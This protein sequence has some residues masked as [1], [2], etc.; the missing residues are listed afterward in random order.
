MKIFS[1][2]ITLAALS[3]LTLT[4]ASYAQDNADN[5]RG[6][7][8]AEG[9][10]ER[11][12]E[13]QRGEQAQRVIQRGR[14]S[15]ETLDGD[16]D[17]RVSENEFLDDRLANASALFERL[18]SDG[19]GL[20][21]LEDRN[22]GRRFNALGARRQACLNSDAA[23]AQPLANAD[24]DGDNY[25]SLNELNGA[26]DA[27]ARTAFAALDGNGDAY[28]DADEFSAQRQQRA[29]QRDELRDCLRA[30]D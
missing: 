1:T 21:G 4:S 8:R 25:L 3:T 29:D 27:Q 10:Q 5:D 22:L 12:A 28:I 7:R 26:L 2:F 30:D 13:R 17:G 16:G 18:D 23:T 6:F 20:I 24:A 15:L 19:D 9:Q 11:R 14:A